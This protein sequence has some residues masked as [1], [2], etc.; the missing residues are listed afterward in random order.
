MHGNLLKTPSC[1]PS[2][3]TVPS[4]PRSPLV[5]AHPPDRV[6]QSTTDLLCTN[7]DV[8]Y[9]GQSERP[10]RRLSAPRGCVS[11][12][13]SLPFTPRQPRINDP[14]FYGGC[15]AGTTFA[16]Y[17]SLGRKCVVFLYIEKFISLQFCC[18]TDFYFN[19]RK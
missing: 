12:K 15:V 9:A 10:I 7:A 16:Y 17:G 2:I 5:T 3:R 6:M 19:H 13:R 18:G 4:T 14:P 1:N 8:E 11:I